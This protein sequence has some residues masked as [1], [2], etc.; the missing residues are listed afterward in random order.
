MNPQ[1]HIR[2]AASRPVR[3]RLFTLTSTLVALAIVPASSR[4]QTA[5]PAKAE[6]AKDVVTLPTFTITETP[7]N[8]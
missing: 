3:R 4:A 2:I 6:G 5:A 7:A 1:T 8:P